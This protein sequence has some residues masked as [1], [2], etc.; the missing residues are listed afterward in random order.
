MEERRE[1]VIGLEKLINV[2]SKKEWNRINKNR[3]SHS[4]GG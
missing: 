4:M 2:N 1:T 3:V